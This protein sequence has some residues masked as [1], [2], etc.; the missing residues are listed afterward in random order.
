MATPFR[1]EWCTTRRTQDSPCRLSCVRNLPTGIC[2]AQGRSP[3]LCC[4]SLVGWRGS[5]LGG[6]LGVEQ[7]TN[8]SCAIPVFAICL[9][10]S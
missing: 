5:D 8:T 6:T 9:S 3:W 2:R 1:R 4:D 10:S 7:G